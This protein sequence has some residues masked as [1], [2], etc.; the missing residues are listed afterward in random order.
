MSVG[1][2]TDTSPSRPSSDLSWPGAPTP[3]K[4]HVFLPPSWCS[5]KGRRIIGLRCNRRTRNDGIKGLRMSNRMTS[6]DGIEGLMMSDRRTGNDGI[7]GL[8][9]DVQQRRRRPGLLRSS[10]ASRPGAPT[11]YIFF[12]F[13]AALRVRRYNDYDAIEGRMM[14]E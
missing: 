4:I 14:T 13:T 12:F 7:E 11:A 6:N 10:P 3:H 8:R 9:M 5:T 1:R 2:T